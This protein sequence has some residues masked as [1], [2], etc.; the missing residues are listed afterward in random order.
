MYRKR[1]LYALAALLIVEGIVIVA[2]PSRMPRA[3]RALTAAVDLAVAG[4]VVL[5]ARQRGT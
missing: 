3:A 5:I 2:I 1:T 4:A